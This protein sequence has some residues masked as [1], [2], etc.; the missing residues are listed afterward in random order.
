MTK[1]RLAAISAAALLASCGGGNPLSNPDSISNPGSTTGQKLSFIYFQQCIN[2]IYDTS[3]QVNQGGVISTNTCSSGGCHD[4]STGTGGALRLIR[5]AAQVPVA[6]PPDADAIRATD[7][8]KNFYSS[9][10]ATV[11]GSPAQSRLLAKPLLTVLH[12][13]GQI[14]T[15]AQD[16]NAARIA[17][18]IS[19]P[20]PQG[21]DEFSV[22][23]NSMFTAGVCNQ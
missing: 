6:D 16:N 11:I 15:N 2:G 8:Y 3:L 9:Q 5:G 1:K 23:G 13:G 14:F 10:G 21:Q 20:M 22:A 17:Y 7:M 18:W 19:R 12:G 4:T